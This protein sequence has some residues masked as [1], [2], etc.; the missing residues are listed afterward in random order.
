[1]SKDND[2]LNI[3]GALLGIVASLMTI[4][5]YFNRTTCPCDG[6]RLPLV[7]DTEIFGKRYCATCKEW[8]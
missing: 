4:G 3:V 8:H 7:G 2:W 1:M 6:T 5:A